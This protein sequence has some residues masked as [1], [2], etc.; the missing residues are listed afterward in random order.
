[1]LS[2]F[3]REKA[4][5]SAEGIQILPG[6]TTGIKRGDGPRRPQLEPENEQQR[7]DAKSAASM[8]DGDE[9][10]DRKKKKRA[11]SSP[12]W[13]GARF[14]AWLVETFGIETLSRGCGVLDIAG[15]SGLT[16]SALCYQYGI[17]CTVVDPCPLK[18]PDGRQTALTEMRQEAM[19]RLKAGQAADEAVA[20]MKEAAIASL[21]AGQGAEKESLESITDTSNSGE[22]TDNKPAE[23][24]LDQGEGKEVADTARWEG[25]AGKTAGLNYGSPEAYAAGRY[26][27]RDFLNGSCPLGEECSFVHGYGFSK[28]EV[29]AGAPA[30][31]AQVQCLFDESFLSAEATKRLWEEC[32]VVVAL[33]PDEATSPVV[34]EA[35]QRGK[36][37]AVVPCCVYRTQF[38]HRLTSAGKQVV[39]YDDLCDHLQD[40]APDIQRGQLDIPGRNTAL[41]WT[42]QQAVPGQFRRDLFAVRRGAV[43]NAKNRLQ[44]YQ[45][46]SGGSKPLYST[47][48]DKPPFVAQVRVQAQGEEEPRVYT[49]VAKKRKKEAEEDAAEVA[50]A[51]MGIVEQPQEDPADD[52]EQ[53]E[54]T[55][56]SGGVLFATLMCRKT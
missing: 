56:A 12:K 6:S 46:H 45:H 11:A 18:P 28:A 43:K 47:Q 42:D 27:C 14:A 32:S 50:L 55:G 35:I 54:G 10:G 8:G 9:V 15:G 22:A 25:W 4:V 38:P 19:A 23:G 30:V 41:Y 52:E 24:I 48:S 21:D 37:F 49:G 2:P 51:A 36:P 34:M 3:L 16:A 39:S 33:H 53:G 29:E 31:P 7:G 1:M 17:P 20:A 40:L 26:V 13:R 5:E 44:E